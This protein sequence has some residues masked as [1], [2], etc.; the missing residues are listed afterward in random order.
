MNSFKK[1]AG[2]SFGLVA[3]C[4]ATSPAQALSV[5]ANVGGSPTGVNRLNF[6]DMTVGSSGVFL[7]SGPNG[8]VTVTLLPGAQVA[9]GSAS[10]LYAAPYLSSDNGIGFGSGG[11]DQPNGVDLTPYLSTGRTE[12]STRGIITFSFSTEQRYLGLLWGSVD[13]YNHISFFMDTTPVGVV[14]GTDPAFSGANGGDQGLNGTRYVN[15]NSDLPFNTVVFTSDNYAF[16]FDN[17]SY[18][19]NQVGVPDG[20]ST[21]AMLLAATIGLGFWAKRKS[22]GKTESCAT[23]KS[24]V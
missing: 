6:D 14:S 17:V 13:A 2:L 1:F 23:V 18:R 9:Q 24:K 4:Y 10:G 12:G 3:V 20:G 5:V 8:S 11:S 19:Q 21:T 22:A 15:I 16:E 7:A